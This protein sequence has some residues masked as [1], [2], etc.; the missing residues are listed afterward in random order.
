LALGLKDSFP[1]SSQPFS[2]TF[3]ITQTLLNQFIDVINFGPPYLMIT[4]TGFCYVMVFSKSENGDF[5]NS[6]VA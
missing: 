2:I 6:Q 4:S 5:S 1:S 3:S